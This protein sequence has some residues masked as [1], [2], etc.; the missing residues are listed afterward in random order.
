MRLTYF[1]LEN[2]IGIYNGMGIDHIEIDFS[3]CIYPIT[4]IKG[5][6]GTGKSSLLNAINP[7]SDPLSYLVPGKAG[8]KR[9]AYQ[10]SDYKIL[11]ISY[12][13]PVDSNGNRKP[14]TCSVVVSDQLGSTELNPNHNVND[15]KA[16]ICRELDIDPSFL[17]LAQL[18]SSDRGLADKKPA[19]R[20]MFINKQIKDL[21]VYNGFHKK[22]SKRSSELRAMTSDLSAKIARIG[23]IRN[24]QQDIHSKEIQ[25]DKLEEQKM[26]ISAESGKLK[27]KLDEFNEKYDN[28][29]STKNN[30][31]TRMHE[32]ESYILQNK[33]VRPD[34]M[35]DTDFTE[36]A[37]DSMKQDVIVSEG[38][39]K[40]DIQEIEKL[41]EEAT[42]INNSLQEKRAKLSA[43]K[44]TESYAS[45]KAKL[46]EIT[47]KKNSAEE[48]LINRLPKG[49][50]IS[51]I[52]GDEY[53]MVV[54][55]IESLRNDKEELLA[56]DQEAL[57]YLLQD[58][59]SY[60]SFNGKKEALIAFRKNNQIAAERLSGNIAS[61]NAILEEQKRLSEQTRDIANIPKDCPHKSTCPFIAS[62]VAANDRIFNK[63]KLNAFLKTKE[64]TVKTYIKTKEDIDKI[65]TEIACCDI[66]IRMEH[67]INFAKS[68]L[69]KF[70][71][72]DYD[73]SSLLKK[74]MTS[75]T[76]ILFTVDI[77]LLADLNN[78]VIMYKAYTADEVALS[79]KL[80][81]L[82]YNAQAVEMLEESIHELE[83]SSKDALDKIYTITCEKDRY[84]EHISELNT[85]IQVVE[86][87][88]ENMKNL[89][90]Y[91]DE[92][93]SIKVD[94]DKLED[95]YNK[96]KEYETQLESYKAQL[97]E[98]ITKEIPAIQNQI[99]QNKYKLVLYNDYKTDYEKYSSEFDMIESIR[100][101]CSPTSGLQTIYME[102]YMNSVI[103]VS[104]QLLSM[105]FGGE[106]VLQPFVINDKEFRMPVL[107]SY[108]LND[109]ISSMSTSQI[110]MISMIISFALLHQSS[111][112]YNIIKLDE[113]EGGLDTRNRL[114]FF[115]VL[116][117]L[118]Q[119]L[120]FDQ[121][122]MISHNTEL[123]MGMMDII[124]LK[125]SDPDLKL[126]GNVIFNLANQK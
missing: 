124:V 120:C 85:K 26:R 2:Y 89:Q 6:N 76:D 68:I 51:N 53:T 55:T 82:S 70:F 50:S 33:F 57:E 43:I 12:S 81:E 31:S 83:T 45:I 97:V 18:S 44:G 13:Y 65:S 110:C 63:K 22:L 1:Y 59:D 58:I 122:I 80:A 11:T 61:M 104:N 49:V 121:C 42:K 54:S 5:D 27:S 123:N 19:E 116:S 17:I 15:G 8:K 84:T 32:L 98:I 94:C 41:R 111:S 100:R 95:L 73:A 99:N 35:E 78:L 105:F 23:D 64:D 20:K 7:F 62:I 106:Y 69:S 25:L 29:I 119:Q 38:K 103:G 87:Y 47:N 21:D 117:A 109:D 113:L 36:R 16:I 92:Y 74:F 66:L 60:F 52:T 91:K 67:T 93:A 90:E 101:C 112:V 114:S 14:T 40:Y 46:D 115:N 24:I 34:Y 71:S 37:L 30:L 75:Y 96:A 9:I 77:S 48:I 72:I 39:V 79:S 86:N 56:K 10:L 3:K 108:I 126:D 28:P 4:V 88:F 125:N 102:M 118:M 107:G